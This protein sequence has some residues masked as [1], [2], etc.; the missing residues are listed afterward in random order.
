[1]CLGGV[2]LRYSTILSICLAVCGSWLNS[3][4]RWLALFPQEWT[5]SL[6]PADCSVQWHL[7][8]WGQFITARGT[9][10]ERNAAKFRDS[11]QMP[12]PYRTA[13]CTFNALRT[14]LDAL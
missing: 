13:Y 4:P 7:G 6:S 1:M 12:F 10:H 5:D 9:F 14:H 3:H 11:G 2:M 8:F